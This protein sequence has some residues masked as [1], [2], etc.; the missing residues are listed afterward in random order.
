MVNNGHKLELNALPARFIHAEKPPIVRIRTRKGRVKVRFDSKTKYR[1]MYAL[2][3]KD[4]RAAGL[5]VS[6][7]AR[8]IG[9]EDKT[10][11][12]WSYRYPAFAEAWKLGTEMAT[13]RVEESL[14]KRALGYAVPK[15]KVAFDRDGNVLR[16]T[17][18]EHVPAD[19]GAIKYWLGNRAPDQW[20]ERQS[21]EH[22][23]PDGGP[24]EL[25]ARQA[26]ISD[27]LAELR[28]VK[29]QEPLAL[30]SAPEGSDLL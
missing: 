13:G 19:V 6:E 11:Y 29:R 7:I 15:E 27:L 23:G 30:E 14:Y 2:Q 4:M 20:R 25:Q 5:T 8:T 1:P 18:Q 28:Q 21:I 9:V 17:Y 10:L 24:I 12:N 26:A 3:V 16:A 22:S